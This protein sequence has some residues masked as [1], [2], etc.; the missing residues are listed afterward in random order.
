[1]V[2]L[3]GTLCGMVTIQCSSASASKLASLLLGTDAASNRSMI[4]DAMG[5]LCNMVAGNF[6]AK[7]SPLSDHWM[8]S[9]PTVIMGDDYVMKTA[10]PHEGV[11][12]SL[13]YEESLIWISILIQP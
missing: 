2:G 13:I 10:E 1:M 12:F 5:E 9:I 8:M 4:A 11:L 3:A 6:K 7:L